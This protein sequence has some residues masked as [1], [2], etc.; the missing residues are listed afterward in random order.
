MNARLGVT[1]S[2]ERYHT[3]FVAESLGMWHTD[4]RDVFRDDE[5]ECRVLKDLPEFLENVFR[6]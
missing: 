5:V 4:T 2:A 3:E 6:S 1:I